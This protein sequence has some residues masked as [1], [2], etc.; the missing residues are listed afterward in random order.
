MEHLLEKLAR[1]DCKVGDSENIIQ[2]MCVMLMTLGM[3]WV[4]N[5]AI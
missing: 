5:V 3:D 1:C 4:T 2:S